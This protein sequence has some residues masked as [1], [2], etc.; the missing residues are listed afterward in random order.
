MK[1]VEKNVLCIEKD[2]QNPEDKTA[3]LFQAILLARM[4]HRMSEREVRRRSVGPVQV[5]AS[6]SI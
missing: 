3:W 4:G 2:I 5:R 6:G 1:R